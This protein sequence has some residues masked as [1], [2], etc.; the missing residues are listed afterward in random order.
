MI[1]EGNAKLIKR[2]ARNIVRKKIVKEMIAKI[3]K[4]ATTI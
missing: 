4:K 2:G 3:Q 1:N